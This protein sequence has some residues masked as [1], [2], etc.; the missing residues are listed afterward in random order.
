MDVEISII[1]PVFN[2]KEYLP[3][4]VKSLISQNINEYEI[5]L[6]DDGSFDGSEIICDSYAKEFPELIKCIHKTN[7]GLSSARNTGMR[8]AKGKYVI[9]PDPDDWTETNYLRSLLDLQE[10]Y[11]VDL[12]CTGYYVEYDDHTLL[13]NEDQNTIV[14]S[15]IE[16]QKA[17]F[18]PP[19]MG[20]FAWN[21]LYHLDIIKKNSLSFLDD[22]GTTE[23]L[24]FAFRYMQYC[25]EV[26]FAPSIRTYHY[27]QRK[28]ATTH[29]GFSEK[30]IES[31]YTYEKI[32][33][34]AGNNSDV[35]AAAKE[36]IC[37]TAI[38]LIIMYLN[39]DT[40][41][42]KLYEELKSIY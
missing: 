8:A 22:V 6:I 27:Y 17:L 10:K 4:C 31:I 13:A 33:Q 36:E 34:E 24:D 30:K 25:S 3:R 28:D 20:G 16:A 39:S 19:S 2:L 38:N 7:G 42:Q 1:V 15:R 40:N 23:D 9:F 41:N 21:K 11:C 12:C 18:V 35:I 14:M 29:S 37:N 5:I 32:I 26:C